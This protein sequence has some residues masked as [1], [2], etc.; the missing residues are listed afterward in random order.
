MFGYHE[1]NNPQHDKIKTNP[2]FVRTGDVQISLDTYKD[3]TD[4]KKE[5]HSSRHGKSVVEES[6]TDYNEKVGGFSLIFPFNKTS[7]SLAVTAYKTQS[8]KSPINP[9]YTRMIVSELKTYVS[10]FNESKN[11]K[12]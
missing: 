6:K 2:S 7:E 1:T 9:N 3:Q 10:Q 11:T 8:V 4:R 5:K 12:R